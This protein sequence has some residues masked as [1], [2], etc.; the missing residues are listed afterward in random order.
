MYRIRTIEI[1]LLTTLFVCAGLQLSG[2]HVKWIIFSILFMLNGFWIIA[3][4]LNKNNYIKG[5]RFSDV[6]EKELLMFLLWGV[7]LNIS[8]IPGSTRV[9]KISLLILT[10]Y[11]FT[12]G[13]IYYIK[14]RYG[15]LHA[16]EKILF[17]FILFGFFLRF[18]HFS[19]GGILHILVFTLLSLVLFLFGFRI[20]YQMISRHEAWFGILLLVDYLL[21]AAIVNFLLFDSMFWQYSTDFFLFSGLFFVII[22]AIL[23]FRYFQNISKITAKVQIHFCLKNCFR[24]NFVYAFIAAFLFLAEPKQQLRL[25]YGNRPEIIK[26]YYECFIDSLRNSRSCLKFRELEKRYQAGTYPEDD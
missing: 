15:R 1:I 8:Y 18:M 23:I 24:R 17:S 7:A 12:S 26:A 13:I 11:Y 25:N 6:V 22:N 20:F 14:N 5:F 10:I 19:G 3:Y 9:V 21:L 2:I 4:I 16:T